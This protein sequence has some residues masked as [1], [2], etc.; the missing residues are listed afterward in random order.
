VLPQDVGVGISQVLPVIVVALHSNSGIVAIEQPELH[1]H[2]AFQVALGDLF[3]SQVKEQNVCFLLETH[4]EHLL[5]RM[6]RRIRETS[7]NSLPPDVDGL[8]PE[9]LS[10]C[11][12]VAQDGCKYLNLRLTRLVIRWVDGG[13][14]S[15]GIRNCVMLY[16]SLLR[17]ALMD[18]TTFKYLT[19][20]GVSYG[21][22]IRNSHRNERVDGVEPFGSKLGLELER[23]RKFA[24]VNFGRVYKGDG[25][26]KLE[27]LREHE[28]APFQ[29]II[30]DEEE[31]G[32][33]F[34]L[35]AQEISRD[36]PRWKIPSEIRV[37]RTKEALCD[38]VTPLLKISK[39]I[40]FIDRHFD[41]GIPR[42]QELLVKFIGIACPAQAI[43]PVLEYHFSINDDDLLIS[44]KDVDFENY[45]RY[46][47]EKIM[48]AGIEMKLFRWEKK[49][50][51]DDLHARYILTEKGG[52]RIDWGLDPGKPGEKTPVMLLPHESWHEYWAEYEESSKVFDLIDHVIIAGKK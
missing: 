45:C 35:R 43:A 38:A 13:G 2:P 18:W 16:G 44:R 20:N 11:Y 28:L 29:A 41:P 40:K 4:S 48:P 52:L 31:A 14:F 24:I 7:E 17:Q 36:T 15:E 46:H 26:W 19:G 12:V 47:L 30:A 6:L 34:V 50:H 21:R 51:G 39:H 23:L 32:M 1:I 22:L 3:I 10:I 9:Q 27:A 42:W 37:P 5:L 25:A 49:H 33:D 8:T